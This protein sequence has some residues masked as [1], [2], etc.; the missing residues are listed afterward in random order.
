MAT[1]DDNPARRAL[2]GGAYVLIALAVHA[3]ILA[4]LWPHLRY[5][6]TNEGEDP[7]A[8]TERVEA[9]RPELQRILDE[10]KQAVQLTPEQAVEMAKPT[11]E[12]AEKVVRDRLK[13]ARDDLQRIQEERQRAFDELRKRDATKVRAAQVER[14][15]DE[16]DDF[17]KRVDGFWKKRDSRKDE[18]REERVRDQVEEAKQTF[19]KLKEDPTDEDVRDQLIEQV[20]ATRNEMY[21]EMNDNRGINGPQQNEASNAGNKA[22]D[23]VEEIEATLGIDVDLEEMNDTSIA[24]DLSLEQRDS[25]GEDL[26]SQY[27]A[28]VDVEQAAGDA[29]KDAAAAKAA[30]E[31]GTSFAEEREQAGD[32]D[33]QRPDLAEALRGEGGEGDA[34]D[35]GRVRDAQEAARNHASQI[36]RRT[37]S[38]ANAAAGLPS[39]SQ[40]QQGISGMTIVGSGSAAGDSNDDLRRDESGEI[41]RMEHGTGRRDLKLETWKVGRSALPGRMFTDESTR[42][43]WLYVDTW[44]VIGPWENE[45]RTDYAVTHPPEFVIDLDAEYHDGKFANRPGH[46]DEVLR[47]EFYQSD[48]IRQVPPRVYAA[49]TFY[50]YTEIYSDRDRELLLSLASDDAAKMWLN[51]EVVWQ[52]AGLSVHNVGEGFRRV[53]V[54]QGYNT[55]LVRLE[56]GP[57]KAIW[58]VV[59]CPPEIAERVGG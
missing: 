2:G 56:N 20:A 18:R 13:Q 55:L 6:V 25:S 24:S 49:S 59:L 9:M 27:E 12:R 38:L 4:V 45:Y 40:D 11:E 58:S 30:V 29:A 8:A 39:T 17:E 46:P 33:P 48:E 43:G 36:A 54:R 5:I 44:F 35:Y 14:L 28:I 10:K 19:A 32:V 7:Q 47:W 41:S 15:Q 37:A 21:R 31:R 34:S 42:K 52:D 50:A 26:A 22:R 57:A 53:N 16:F 51:G 3:A 1:S 23:L